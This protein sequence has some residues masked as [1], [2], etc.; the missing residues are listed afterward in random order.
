MI[1]NFV[2]NKSIAIIK[3]SYSNYNQEQLEKIQ[4]G[5]EAIYLSLTKVFVIIILSIILNIF[6]ETLALLLFFNLLRFTGFGLHASKSWGCWIS[7]VPTFIGLPLVCKHMTL[8]EYI[9]IFIAVFSLINFLLF[10]PADT[11][12]RPLIR[13][14]RRII[15]KVLTCFTGLIYLIVILY[16]KN[17][18]IKNTLSFA[19]LIESLLINPLTYKLFNTTYNNYKHYTN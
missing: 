16:S 18:F 9:L 15:Y 12:K 5:L 2:I 10:A 4:Y 7:S 14:K 6:Y 11:K 17:D 19:M 1:K 3:N 8:S 13:K